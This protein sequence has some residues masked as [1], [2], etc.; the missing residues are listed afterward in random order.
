MQPKMQ[1]ETRVANKA[2][3]TQ[4]ETNQNESARTVYK[5]TAPK[6]ISTS[7]IN[8]AS[9]KTAAGE[10]KAVAMRGS[11]IQWR[12]PRAESTYICTL[13]SGYWQGQVII[14]S[15]ANTLTPTV[16]HCEVN[17]PVQIL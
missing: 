7:T 1:A 9:E 10:F 12:Q 6:P 5:Y 14:R 8:Q 2:R 3:G 17:N 13:V 4:A 16:N 15:Q 11:K